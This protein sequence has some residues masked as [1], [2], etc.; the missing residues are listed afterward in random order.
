M[1]STPN[2]RIEEDDELFFD[3][4]Q[5]MQLDEQEELLRHRISQLVENLNYG[6]PSQKVATQNT[7][8]KLRGELHRVGQ[9]NNRARWT[10]AIRNV[11]GQEGYEAVRLE[12][13]R[14]T[15]YPYGDK[16]QIKD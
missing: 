7:L 10:V 16:N 2:P 12:L 1:F 3:R 5:G 4:L 8:T 13:E 11:F 15:G 6:T 14:L 9:V